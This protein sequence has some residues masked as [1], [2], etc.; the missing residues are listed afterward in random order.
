MREREDAGS[1]T[2]KRVVRNVATPTSNQDQVS[3]RHGSAGAIGSKRNCTDQSIQRTNQT[4]LHGTSIT[5]T[6]YTQHAVRIQRHGGN[7]LQPRVRLSG[8]KFFKECRSTQPPHELGGARV[9]V[10][11]PIV[12][13]SHDEFDHAPL[14]LSDRSPKFEPT[15]KFAMVRP[16]S[17]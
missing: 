15:R 7:N 5:N 12:T 14:P 17:L 6:R 11:L 16:K 2:L 13:Q 9:S 4:R 10:E 3:G 8:L 1:G